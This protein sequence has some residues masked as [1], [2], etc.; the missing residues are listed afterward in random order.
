M[1]TRFIEKRYELKEKIEKTS[2]NPYFHK[3]LDINK[4]A[5]IVA[6]GYL[7]VASTTNNR[8]T[9]NT[10]LKLTEMYFNSDYDKN[11]NIYYENGIINIDLLKYQYRIL[12]K[13]SHEETKQLEWRLIPEERNYS[14]VK[15]TNS[16][17]KTIKFDSKKL[18]HYKELG[19]RNQEFYEN[20]DYLIKAV[21]TLK[22]D[23]YVAY[24]YPNGF[25]L[26]D[27]EYKENAPS[28][29]VGNAIYYMHAT[30]FEF[31][32]RL[33]KSLLRKHPNVGRITHQGAWEERALKII[34]SEG[35]NKDIEKTI[36]IVKQLQKQ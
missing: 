8:Y 24:I 34:N 9:R 36:E 23:G 14:I 28:T 7:S 35:S 17:P 2:F 16:K 5:M 1:Y 13:K 15:S 25:I 27:K 32:S 19:K 29:A 22:F 6:K 26:L 31:L 33:D 3:Y 30:D 12:K 10:Y 18:A 21:G 20:T 4:L 11:I